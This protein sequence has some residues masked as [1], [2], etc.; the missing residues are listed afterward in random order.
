MM[1]RLR[2]DRCESL[3]RRLREKVDVLFPGTGSRPA[4]MAG[5]EELFPRPGMLGSLKGILMPVEEISGPGAGRPPEPERPALVWGVKP[6][7]MKG[8]E[9]IDRIFQ[10]GFTDTLY[11]ARRGKLLFAGLACR[12][13]ADTCFCD[14]V[15]IDRTSTAGMDVVMVEDG[16]ELLLKPLTSAGEELAAHAGEL[17]D[18]GRGGDGTRFEILLAGTSEGN[19]EGQS[20]RM[21]VGETAA[22]MQELWAGDLWEKMSWTCL[23][24]GACSFLCPLCW[25]F[26]VRDVPRAVLGQLG[27]DPPGCGAGGEEGRRSVRI[28]CRDS[29]QLGH[30][31]RMAGGADP[32]GGE[33]ARMRHRFFHK[34]KYIPD[35]YGMLGCSGC[36]RCVVACPQGIDIRDIVLMLT[37]K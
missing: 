8:L 32:Y 20:A 17:L 9:L 35:E 19:I 1:F 29:C 4:A 31:A 22:R 27:G 3:I 24:C 28:R 13:K 15:G 2:K 12:E 6:C 14:L 5:P 25:C 36:G 30:Y 18:R 16:E 26:D 7:D 23:G 33:A 37:K 21:D 11:A 34:F 10:E